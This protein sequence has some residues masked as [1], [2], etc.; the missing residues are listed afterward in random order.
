MRIILNEFYVS[1]RLIEFKKIVVMLQKSE[2][3]KS[4]KR[5]NKVKKKNLIGPKLGPKKS[6]LANKNYVQ[7]ETKEDMWN[8]EKI[9]FK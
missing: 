6:L 7:M 9:N 1:E 5:N 3:W 2:R 4:N 8:M